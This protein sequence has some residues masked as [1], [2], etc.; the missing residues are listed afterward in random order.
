MTQF[1]FRFQKILELK[2]NEKDFAQIQ[3]ADAIKHQEIGF[4]KK[5]AIQHKIMDAERLKKEKQQGGINISELRMLESYIHQLQ[6]LLFSSN[7]ELVHLQNNVVESQSH[8]QM[9]AQEEK[10]W[11]NLKQ[12]K[13][14]QFEEQSKAAE[15][16]FFDEL[17][18]TRFYRT[19]QAS[20]AERG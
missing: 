13:K 19:A 14:T 11:E 15:N 16:S 3:M 1:N 7:R 10:T 4:R 18:S 17:A 5:E 2:E 12:K 6:E 8:L 9:K 20:L